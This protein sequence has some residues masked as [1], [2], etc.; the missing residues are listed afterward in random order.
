MFSW[1]FSRKE[2]DLKHLQV[3]MLTRAGCHLCAEAWQTLE[4]AQK[5][6]GFILQAVDVDG[7]P[8]LVSRYGDCVPVVLIDGK[9]RFRGK[10]NPALLA[11]LLRVEAK[12]TTKKP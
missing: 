9:V 12:R 3:R 6:H 7:D 10:I 4:T 8:K 1:F 11:R 2:P 5:Q